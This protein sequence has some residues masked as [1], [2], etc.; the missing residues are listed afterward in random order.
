MSCVVHRVVHRVMHYGAL[1]GALG[2]LYHGYTHY[3][4]SRLEQYRR[5]GTS[6]TV[7]EAHL[8]DMDEHVRARSRRDEAE[9]AG[10]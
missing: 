3:A 7:L 6:E 2:V 10:T 9:P 1:C 5:A 4:V 8:R